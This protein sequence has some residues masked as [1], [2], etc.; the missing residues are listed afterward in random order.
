MSKTFLCKISDLDKF[1][2]KGLSVKIKRKTHDIFIVKQ[3]DDFFAYYNECPHRLAQLEWNADD[4]L[5]AD[6]Q[7]IICAM[8][9]A[10]F[11]L[12]DG[13]C[14][15]GPCSGE[16]LRQIPIKIDGEDIFLD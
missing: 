1:S 10:L 8:H 14:V 7:H 13:S 6:K 5:T 12:S 2:S 9:G 16:S 15:S 11:T 3:D 4:F